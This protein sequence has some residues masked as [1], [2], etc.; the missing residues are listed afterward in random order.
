MVLFE[1]ME[2]LKSDINVTNSLLRILDE[3]LNISLR[4]IINLGIF[5][6]YSILQLLE[7][8]VIGITIVAR[9]FKRQNDLGDSCA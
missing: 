9:K 5:L 7:Y 3:T 8:L 2:R 1:T 4:F 6:G